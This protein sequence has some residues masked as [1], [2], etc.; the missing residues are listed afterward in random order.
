VDLLGGTNGLRRGYTGRSEEQERGCEVRDVSGPSFRA[1]P[2]LRQATRVFYSVK[3]LKNTFRAELEQKKFR[4]LQ[5]LYPR[6][7][8]NVRGRAGPGPG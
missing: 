2:G 8:S 7:S 1:G 3:Q 4:R 5:D 6:P